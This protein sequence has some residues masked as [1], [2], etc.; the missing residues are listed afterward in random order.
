MYK[1]YVSL[2][3]ITFGRQNPCYHLCTGHTTERFRTA[4]N[5][6]NRVLKENVFH[7]SYHV[8][9]MSRDARK[10]VLGDFDQV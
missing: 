2:Q 4:H 10:P 3:S 8:R 9:Y 5:F 7:I 1:R 6:G